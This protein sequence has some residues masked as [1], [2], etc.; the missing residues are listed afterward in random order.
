MITVSQ[1]LD[2]GNTVLGI[3]KGGVLDGIYRVFYEEDNSLVIELDLSGK[4]FPVVL[5]CLVQVI[6]IQFSVASVVTIQLTGQF[7]LHSSVDIMSVLCLFTS[8]V[9]CLL[10]VLPTSHISLFRGVAS[11]HSLGGWVCGEKILLLS[12]SIYSTYSYYSDHTSLSYYSYS[13]HTLSI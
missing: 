7:C 2:C 9:V 12:L 3:S 1:I 13:D 10:V 5:E 11:S 8:C 4:Q 6:E